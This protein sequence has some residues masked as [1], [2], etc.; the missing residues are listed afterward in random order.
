MIFGFL[1]VFLVHFLRTQ[2]K[3]LLGRLWDDWRESR[4][5]CP[6]AC[7]LRYPHLYVFRD[8]RSPFAAPCNKRVAFRL[9]D[10]GAAYPKFETAARH[11]G[12]GS[13]AIAVGRPNIRHA[14]GCS[15]H[16]HTHSGSGPVPLLVSD[17]N[18]DGGISASN[19][20]THGGLLLCG[21]CRDQT[22]NRERQEPKMN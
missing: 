4:T 16:L 18:C 1:P 21:T 14:P 15:N 11:A 20:R 22:S 9:L 3:L 17:T 2:L 13:A 12:E 19:T 7:R 8:I 10:V 6:T 5:S